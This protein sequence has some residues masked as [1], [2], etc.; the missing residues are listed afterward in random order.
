LH[1]SKIFIKFAVKNN[2]MLPKDFPYIKA[3]QVNDC[4][5][6]QNFRIDLPLAN[7]KP[8][9]HLIITGKNGS[10]KS[11]ILRGVGR[12]FKIDLNVKKMGTELVE[13]LKSHVFHSPSAQ[14]TP[15]WQ[16]QIKELETVIPSFNTDNPNEF[17]KENQKYIFS[18]FKANRSSIANSVSSV[19]KETDLLTNLSSQNT[20]DYFISQFKQFLVNK[21]VNQAFDQIR[22]NT[23]GVNQTNAFFAKLTKAFQQFFEDKNLELIFE[24]TAFEFYIKLSDGRRLMFNQ[25]SDG[26][27]AFSGILMDLFMRLDIARKS[28][29]DVNADPCGIVLL[30]EPEN[31][32]HIAAQY[33][34]MPTLIA[35]FP[36]VQFIIATHSPAVISSIK[37]TT[38]FDLTSKEYETDKIVGSSFSELMVSHFGLD[39]E[40]SPIADTIIN[41][42]NKALKAYKNDKP[43]LNKELG[44]IFIENQDYLSPTLKIELESLILKAS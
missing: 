7:G 24:E 42:V 4:F 38:V 2:I 34:V 31:H 12:Y 44:R 21:K 30:D 10:G 17:L 19:T 25:L 22:H 36:N 16:N 27:A 41:N 29:N 40:F 14:S 37:N 20:S 5:T 8:F 6:Y 18:Y 26:F 33:Q 43:S 39:N 13:T 35:F 11:S 28:L 9:S 15:V 32:L 3:I 1:K 23:E